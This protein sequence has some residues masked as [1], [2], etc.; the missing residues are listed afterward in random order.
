[1]EVRKTTTLSAAEFNEQFTQLWQHTTFRLELRDFYIA[2]NEQNP[3]ARF[4]AGQQQDLSW[5]GP[6]RR[7]VSRAT[8]A[9]RRMQRVHVVTEPLTPYIEFELT[10]AYPSSVA[11]GEDIRIIPR[12]EASGLHLPAHDFW[13]FDSRLVA[14]LNYDAAG[15]FL[16]VDLNEDPDV[17]QR[18][19]QWRDIVLRYATPLLVYLDSKNLTGLV[20]ANSA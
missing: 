2:A 7:V 6:W 3:F 20:A 1:M 8:Q 13:L 10:C 9:G 15:N 12:G 18:H 19:C 11:A 4:Q 14:L 17:A 5:R 16:T